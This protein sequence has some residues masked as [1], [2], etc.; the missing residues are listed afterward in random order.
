[1]SVGL[2]FLRN[3]TPIPKDGDSHSN[4]MPFT[5]E[6]FSGKKPPKNRKTI[7]YFLKDLP[8]PID[9]SSAKL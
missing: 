2:T 5:P 3:T 9:S 8:L 7:F 1:M 4:S 6:P